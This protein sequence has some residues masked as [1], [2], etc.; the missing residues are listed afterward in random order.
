MG[1]YDDSTAFMGQKGPYFYATFLRLNVIFISTGFI[2]LYIV[3]VGAT[4][5]HNC[6]IPDSNNL[7][8]VWRKAIIP[9]EVV[10]GYEKESKCSRYKLD[11]VRNLSALGYIPG[12]DVNLTEI[13]Q[14]RCLDGWSYSKDIYQSTIVTEWDLVCDNEWKAPFAS[15]TLFIGFLI[16]SLVS[17]LLSDRFGRKNVV[18]GALAVQTLSLFTQAFSPSWEVFC[19]VFTVVGGSSISLYLS[20]FVLGTEVLSKSMRE[21]FT[22]LGAFLHY[23]IGYMILPGIAYAMREWRTLLII[24]S[25]LSVVY[26]PLWWFISESPR[27][28]LSQG[29]VEEAEAILREAARRNRVAAP[30]IIFEDTELDVASPPTKKYSMID[31]VRTSNTRCITLVCLFLWMAV[32]IGYYGLSLNTSNLSGDPHLNCFFSALTEVPAYVVSTILLRKCQRRPLLATFLLLGGG[33]LFVIQ[34]IPNN[35]QGVAIAAEMVGKFAFT[36]CFTVVYI[37]TAEIY[38]TVVRSAGVGMCSSAARLG[39]IAA[40]Y[41]IYLGSVNKYLP[42]II[43]GSMT[44]VVSAGNLLLPET[45]RK[46]LPET[47]EQM[48]QFKGLC[49]KDPNS[50]QKKKG[51][52]QSVFNEVK[53]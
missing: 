19:I 39:T 30:E 33:M 12:L 15:S 21:I 51:N 52:T 28:L 49:R 48:Q 22:T 44:I 46:V 17:G 43:M 37:Y 3:F 4:P 45:F 50:F 10:N 53:F 9:M 38:P 36:V 2:G 23:C 40:P 24:L 29:R 7:S 11:V 5:P 47:V 32:N 20:A 42:Y 16:G 13:E 35:L 27:W 31:V 25:S 14:E 6:F 8:E 1:D 26:I 34:F 18:F 41:V